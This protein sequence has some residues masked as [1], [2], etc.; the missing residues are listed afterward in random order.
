MQLVCDVRCLL[1]ES[2]VLLTRL[3][4]DS[5]EPLRLVCRS[6]RVLVHGKTGYRA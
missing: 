4:D 2:C 6:Y 1:S 5:F 3:Q